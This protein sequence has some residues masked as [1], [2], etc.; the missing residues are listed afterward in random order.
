MIIS[1]D[2]SNKHFFWRTFLV[3]EFTLPFSQTTSTNETSYNF[4]GILK[5]DNVKKFEGKQMN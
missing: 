2:L 4:W 1:L 5:F 3:F